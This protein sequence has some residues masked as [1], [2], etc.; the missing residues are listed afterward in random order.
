MTTE[1][2]TLDEIVEAARQQA[3]DSLTEAAGRVEECQNELDAA[4][5]ERILVARA[6]SKMLDAKEIAAYLG[7][8][9]SLASSLARD[10]E[11]PKRTR[12][13]KEEETPKPRRVKAEDA[14]EGEASTDLFEGLAA[15]AS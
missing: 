14:A 9:E 13:A 7:V 3:K 2:M 11:A 5:A 8:S 10:P 15:N 6:A 12:K 1:G 4:K